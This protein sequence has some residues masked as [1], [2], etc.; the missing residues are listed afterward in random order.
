[1]KKILITGGAGFVGFHLAKK[2]ANN[3]N[4]VTILD[5]FKRPNM[6]EEFKN[7]ISSSNVIFLQNDISDPQTFKNLKLDY[8]DIV[9]HFAAFN[10]T[11]N[12]YDYPA[13]VLKIGSLST[14]YLL[15]WICSHNVRPLVIY[16]SSSETYAGTMKVMEENFPIPTPE[17]IPLTIDDVTNVRW[18]YG[19]SK[20]IG[21]VAFYCYSKSHN[22]DNFNIVRLHNIYGARMGND[23]VISQFIIRFLKNEFP[24]K[25]LGFEQTRSFCYIDDVLEG[26][27]KISNFGIRKEIYHIGNDKEEIKIIDL[28]KILFDV[29]GKEYDFILQEA[30]VG[31]V[32]RRCPNIDKLKSL[33]I[34]EQISLKDGIRKTFEWY[35]EN[36]KY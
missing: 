21:E 29:A 33:N 17:T 20:L 13:E 28:A 31:S 26:L 5:N 19:A 34:K 32:S 12:F 9:Y 18:S 8:Y 35:K 36:Y 14:I 4:E 1:M 25:I 27:E 16:T 24:F 15:E 11:S 7:L 22:F 6:D 23:H 10:G 2:E 3:G 30:P